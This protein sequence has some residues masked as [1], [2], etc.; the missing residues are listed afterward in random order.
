V[1]EEEPAAD[2]R[3]ALGA[4]LAEAMEGAPPAAPEDQLAAVLLELLAA[5]SALRRLAPE[6]PPVARV[7]TEELLNE[8]ERAL[9]HSFGEVLHA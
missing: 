4:A 9:N 5:S 3:R 2:R 6:L 8:L 7:R 1:I